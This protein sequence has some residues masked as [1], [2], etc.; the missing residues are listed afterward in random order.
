MEID[1]PAAFGLMDPMD[2]PTETV[3]TEFFND[4]PDDFD[5]ENLD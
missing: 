3:D 1:D 4:F 2:A 5:D